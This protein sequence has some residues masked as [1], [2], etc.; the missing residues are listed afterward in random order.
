MDEGGGCGSFRSWVVGCDEVAREWS[1]R[2]KRAAGFRC[3]DERG[4]G[5][6]DPHLEFHPQHTTHNQHIPPVQNWNERPA[7]ET[8]DA[9][10]LS[11]YAKGARRPRHPLSATGEKSTCAHHPRP[12]ERKPR[13]S[14]TL[15][16]PCWLLAA[17]PRM[18]LAQR[19]QPLPYE[20]V[21]TKTESS[22]VHWQQPL[23]TLYVGQHNC[24]LS[25][26]TVRA[27]PYY[28]TELARLSCPL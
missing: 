4:K 3:A 5:L 16:P 26:D 6:S 12:Q 8:A 17:Y 28:S 15:Q 19:T 21:R 20:L 11:A 23:R 9:L 1:W 13:R 7:V 14:R 22:L 24:L 18:Y 27:R 10:A 25:T 2:A